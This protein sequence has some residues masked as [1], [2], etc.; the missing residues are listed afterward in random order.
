M[1]RYDSQ[2]VVLEAEVAEDIARKLRQ[3]SLMLYPTDT[4]YGLGCCA[5]EGSAVAHLRRAK[6][7]EARKA[8][9]VIV[10][11]MEQARSVTS[12]WSRAAEQLAASFWPGPLTM[13]LPAAFGLPPELLAGGTTIAIRV[14]SSEVAC[15]LARLAGPLVSTSA[16][17]AGEPPCLT[18]GSAIEAFPGAGVAI[19][20]GPLSGAPSTI[21]DLTDSKTPRILREGRIDRRRIEDCWQP[22]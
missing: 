16:N 2:D 12:F 8:L 19:D 15:Q 4:L 7:R 9:P 6:G 11:D 22:K 14:P 1:T 13:V 5:L 10:G 18:L 21:V 3:G 17:L 20:A